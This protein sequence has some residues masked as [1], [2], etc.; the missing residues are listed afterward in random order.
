MS[1]QPSTDLTVL[2]KAEPISRDVVK[3]IAMDIG[4]DVAAHIEV[5]YP[6]AVEAASSTFLLS[7]RNHVY[8]EIM[9]ALET[10]DEEEILARLETRRGFRR[11]WKA[12][13]RKMRKGEQAEPVTDE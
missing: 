13:Y 2:P 3:Q 10:I 11:K 5:M 1:D 12:G 7:V 9:A 6:Q 4:K 8:N